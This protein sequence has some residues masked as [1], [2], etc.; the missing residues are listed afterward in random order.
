M[1]VTTFF[2]FRPSSEPWFIFLTL[3][4]LWRQLFY[5]HRFTAAVFCSPAP[6]PF[7]LDQRH[8]NSDCSTAEHCFCVC[9]CL[10][11]CV[12]WGGYERNLKRSVWRLQ[13]RC[14]VSVSDTLNGQRMKTQDSNKCF[15]CES[16]QNMHVWTCA[17]ATVCMWQIAQLVS[18]TPA[19]R[20]QWV[21]SLGMMTC[22]PGNNRKQ[23]QCHIFS[24]VPYTVD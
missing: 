11:E 6:F 21:R 12:H 23:K 18:N 16:K 5:E 3:L 19:G 9:E 4:L 13:Q 22:T 1:K 14:Q 8:Q 24:Q 10:C 7:S 20:F 2:A 17:E 15:V